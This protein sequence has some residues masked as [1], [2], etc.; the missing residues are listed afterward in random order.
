MEPNFE[1]N[2]LNCSHGGM[3]AL[4]VHIIVYYF[5]L[6]EEIVSKII[7]FRGCSAGSLFILATIGKELGC[8]PMKYFTYI[9]S[10][11]KLQEIMDLRWHECNVF[12][13]ATKYSALLNEMNK[14]LP[15]EFKNLTFQQVNDINEKHYCIETTTLNLLPIPKFVPM[16]L[17]ST[18]TPNESI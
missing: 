14:V 2:S 12:E 11:E 8:L 13:K 4:V 10:F 15:N 17:S 18:K 6:P 16:T 5:F 3:Y 7:S 1:Y 9:Q